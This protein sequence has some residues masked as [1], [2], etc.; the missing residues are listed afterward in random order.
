MTTGFKNK[1]VKF[2]SD[3]REDIVGYL[4]MFL[5]AVLICIIVFALHGSSDLDP[6]TTAAFISVKISSLIGFFVLEYLIRIRRAI[7]DSKI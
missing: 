2:L 4:M 5:L 3:L 1:I 6:A 7:A